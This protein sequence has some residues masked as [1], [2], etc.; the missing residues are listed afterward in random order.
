MKFYRSFLLFLFIIPVLAIA[1]TDTIPYK[2]LKDSAIS[3]LNDSLPPSLFIGGI[4]IYGNKKTK[5]YIIHGNY[6]LKRAILLH[7]QSLQKILP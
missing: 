6:L 3:G 5:E 1:Q 2:I 4:T 7:R